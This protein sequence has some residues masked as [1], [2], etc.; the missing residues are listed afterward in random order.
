MRNAAPKAMK[1]SDYLAGMDAATT[2]EQLEAAIQAPFKHSYRGPTWSRVCKARIAAGERIVA[3]HPHGQFVPHVGDR[4]QL[5][6]CGESYRVGRGQN[7]A[8]V[9][10]VWHYAEQ[11]ARKI[12][13][14]NGFSDRAVKGI[15][16]SAFDYPH[17]ALETVAEALA[18]KLA[19]PPLN[20]LILHRRSLRSGHPVRI[21]RRIDA[22]DRAHRPCRCGKGWLWDWGAGFSYYT[23]FINWHCDRCSRVYTE[24]LTDGRLGEIRRSPKTAFQSTRA[25]AVRPSAGANT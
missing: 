18:G 15:W 7:G 20:R 21:N 1:L 16:G 5:T 23:S 24:Y 11:W 3:A 2:A 12:L 14:A 10:Y 6:V 4:R 22:K 25:P 8:G 13:N 17:R 9:R 19:D